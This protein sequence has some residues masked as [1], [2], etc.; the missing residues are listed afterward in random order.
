[1]ASFFNIFKQKKE[2]P[3]LCHCAENR[4]YVCCFKGCSFTCKTHNRMKT[5]LKSKHLEW[6]LD[7]FMYNVERW[8][9]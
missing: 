1:M 2:S 5:H 6:V 7:L 8:R 4:P 9:R 3:M